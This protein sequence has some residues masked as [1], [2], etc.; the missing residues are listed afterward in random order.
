M[1]PFHHG[2]FHHGSVQHGP[3]AAV[4]FS[5]PLLGHW[6]LP[7]GRALFVEVYCNTV[8]TKSCFLFNAAPT[9]GHSLSMAHCNMVAKPFQ[10]SCLVS[11]AAA[12]EKLQRG[13][14]YNSIKQY[15][16]YTF[17]PN[18][19][20]NRCLCNSSRMSELRCGLPLRSSPLS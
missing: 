12:S 7:V 13:L 11:S 10:R 20:R 18:I 1:W 2:S 15:K 5:L 9:A 14:K 19:S 8:A 4:F 17:R 6:A 3:N 16:L